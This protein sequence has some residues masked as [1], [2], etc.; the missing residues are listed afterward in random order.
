MAQ[1][2][3]PNGV[4]GSSQSKGRFPFSGCPKGGHSNSTSDADR[5]SA[6]NSHHAQSKE[7]KGGQDK[8]RKDANPAKRKRPST[9]THDQ[10]ANQ[11]PLSSQPQDGQNSN[12]SKKKRVS[13]VKP[14]QRTSRPPKEST[15]LSKATHAF[16][17][18]PTPQSSR[19]EASSPSSSKLGTPS[20]FSAR[21]HT[22]GNNTK[23]TGFFAQQ[24]VET[25]ER[26][27][28]SFCNDHG[29]SGDKFDHMV[30]H[31]DRVK[32]SKFPCDPDVINKPEFWE[33]IYRALPNRDRRSIY[34]FMKRHFQASTQKPHLW[35]DEQDDEL[36][37]LHAQHGPKFAYIAKLLGRSDDDVVQRWKNRLEHRGTMR[38]GA[39]TTQEINDLQTAVEDAY[40]ALIKAGHD[41]G[42]DPYEMEE[43]LIGWGV[44]SDK[45]NNCRSRKQ[46][47][48]KWRKIR[49]NVLNQR[50]SGIPDAVF[51][52]EHRPKGRSRKPRSP[53]PRS[54]KKR[55]TTSGPKENSHKSAEYVFSDDEDGSTTEVQP[56]QGQ[57]ET[58]NLGS[59]A[60]PN[61]DP[62]KGKRPS[63][64]VSTEP[65]STDDHSKPKFDSVPES[66]YDSESDSDFESEKEE[67][68]PNGN[69]S[70]ITATEEDKS[71][72][73]K[74]SIKP[75]STAND[76]KAQSESQSGSE[77]ESQSSGSESESES[78]F[79][80]ESES[81]K[82]SKP[83]TQDAR[84]EH[85]AQIN[86]AHDT[87]GVNGEK[88]NA[89]A[90]V[91][92]D[93]PGTSQNLKEKEPESSE[94][95]SEYGSESDNADSEPEGPEKTKLGQRKQTNGTGDNPA[96]DEDEGKEA[97]ST[98]QTKPL[99]EEAGS[100][101]FESEHESESGSESDSSDNTSSR[102]ERKTNL[103]PLSRASQIPNGQKP[104]VNGDNTKKDASAAQEHAK[105]HATASTKD[106]EPGSSESESESDS[107]SDSDSSDDNDAQQKKDQA[108][109][110]QGRPVR[111]MNNAWPSLNRSPA[112]PQPRAL[113]SARLSLKA[114]R[115]QM[116]KDQ[117]KENAQPRGMNSSPS[118]FNK[119]GGTGK[120]QK[121]IWSPSSSDSESSDD[122]DSDSPAPQRP[123][124]KIPNPKS[125]QREPANPE[126]SIKKN[127]DSDSGD[128]S[129]SSSDDEQ[130]RRSVGEPSSA[131]AKRKPSPTSIKEEDPGPK[132]IKVEEI[133]KSIG[134]AESASESGTDGS[135]SSEDE[136]A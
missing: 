35:T 32:D 94:S 128:D 74:A 29:F 113:P 19:I 110:E 68:A 127:E 101:E 57:Q 8:E 103:E 30:Q 134:S 45:M 126:P 38:K 49:R 40:S 12:P 59:K 100:S 10:S 71:A 53:K 98:A 130:V 66:E 122:S 58:A 121:E 52:P 22:S 18:T 62:Q 51:D 89:R 87:R 43:T 104:A 61:A 14:G 131:N 95:E 21:R 129:D 123:D 48:D 118:S 107:G 1:A 7:G 70:S 124:T 136:E 86:G 108:K 50:V 125:E 27:K 79:D 132:R 75:T 96:T 116:M 73:P 88:E 83:K 102:S 111:Q 76:P 17:S 55:K 4:N 60:S 23:L 105:P 63:T 11:L 36:V 109:P 115:E 41:A 112:A 77:S 84:T 54:P 99:K 15:P 5:P 97:T 117:P 81:E 3:S 16:K 34:R 85:G 42:G 93:K 39:W 37:S 2:P 65:P 69:I 90:S 64:E 135:G 80:G 106:D 33:A 28:L 46:C 31:S 92:K 82:D 120:A 72:S 119:V 47:A 20:K 67:L 91:E 9:D 6:V 56:S 24:E 13:E 133:E 44:V 26:F 25:L 114:I 78:D